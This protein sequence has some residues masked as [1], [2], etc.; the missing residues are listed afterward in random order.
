MVHNLSTIIFV[1]LLSLGKLCTITLCGVYDFLKQPQPHEYGPLY[2][3]WEK[4]DV[5]IPDGNGEV[6]F[7]CLIT[8]L[9][10]W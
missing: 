4:T 2:G 1:P 3:P 6:I 9:K 7:K 8:K 10:T 5:R